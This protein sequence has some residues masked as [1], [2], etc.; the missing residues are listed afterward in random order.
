MDGFRKI[1]IYLQ[2][3]SFPPMGT[4]KLAI[5]S[6]RFLNEDLRGSEEFPKQL[7]NLL[8]GTF[9]VDILTS[10]IIDLQPLTSPLSHRTRE[11]ETQIDEFG[12][13]YRFKS[14]PMISSSAYLANQFLSKFSEKGGNNIKYL[15]NFLY[16]LGWGPFTPRI[17]EHISLSKYDVILGSTFPSTPSYFAFKA[18]NVFNVPFVYAPYFHYRLA[19]FKE[20]KI[21]RIMVEKSSAVIALT[22]TEKRQL[23]LLG[24]SDRKIFVIPLSYDLRFAEQYRV[25]KSN[26][27]AKLGL[28]D[29][30]VILTVPHPFKGGVQTLEAA[31]DVSEYLDGIC[32]VSIGNV[33][34]SYRKVA[35]RI[36]KRHK[37]LK[38]IDY[39]WVSTEMKYLIISAADIF[40]MPS[41]T[42]AFGLSYLDSWSCQTPVIGARETSADDIIFSGENGYLVSFG[43]SKELSLLFRELYSAKQSLEIMGCNGYRSVTERFDLQSVKNKYI[44]VLEF[45]MKN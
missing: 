23:I 24:A 20:N 31:A 39:G 29:K 7:F 19:S 18:S 45:A 12:T 3:I 21:L 32:V 26:A 36:I 15:S 13:I 1:S 16:V 4:K 8:R 2:L 44:E 37:N 10:D 42:D 22:E 9:R 14:H 28:K 41:I 43:N 25:D 34:S 6:N 11:L 40:S 33:N 35:S 17:Y 27:K 30:F 38:I 5:L